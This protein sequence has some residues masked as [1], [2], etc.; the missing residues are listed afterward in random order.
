MF[1][2][3]E[4][5]V[6][7]T[8]DSI[9][10]KVKAEGSG[11]TCAYGWTATVSGIGSIIGCSVGGALIDAMGGVRGSFLICLP[12]VL[13]AVVAILQIKKKESTLYLASVRLS[14]PVSEEL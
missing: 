10:G 14:D 5:L 4:L 3:G 11:L 9:T 13:I 6:S 7:P 8:L 12:A 2:L 1:S